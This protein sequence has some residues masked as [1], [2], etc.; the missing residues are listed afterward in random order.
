[1]AKQISAL[2]N[3]FMKPRIDEVKLKNVPSKI[4]KIKKESI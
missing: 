1:M 3:D 4:K 2:S